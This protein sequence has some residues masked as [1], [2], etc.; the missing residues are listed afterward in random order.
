MDHEPVEIGV[1]TGAHGLGGDV[2]VRLHNPASDLPRP[3]MTID[4]RD[5]KGTR[6]ALRVSD[7]RPAAKGL[8]IHLEGVA[9]RTAAES[10]RGR[11][12]EV[13]R[14]L[15][16][17]LEDGEFYYRDIIGAPVTLADGTP[18]GRVADVFRAATDILAVRKADG[19][20]LLVP[21]VEDFVRSL[22][23]RGV[24]IDPSGLEPA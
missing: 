11:L 15:L 18:F 22:S 8:R 12:I 7:V 4:L 2:I 10:L 16:P 23:P 6:L 3:G 21:V 17:A 9:D 19:G 5:A 13:D 1:I 14:A 24:V 20:E